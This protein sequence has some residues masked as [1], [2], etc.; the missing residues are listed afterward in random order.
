MLRCAYLPWDFGQSY[1]VPPA[2]VNDCCNKSVS[3]LDVRGI[4]ISSIL[5]KV[6]EHCIR[7]R[8]NSFFSNNDNQFG[9]KKSVGCSQAIFIPLEV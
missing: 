6:F 9:F 7:D 5:S 8:Y 4:A 1:T 2:K 3:C